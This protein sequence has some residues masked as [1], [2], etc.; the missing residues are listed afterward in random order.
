MSTAT[1]AGGCIPATG[2]NSRLQK[3]VNPAD[4]WEQGSILQLALDGRLGQDIGHKAGVRQRQHGDGGGGVGLQPLLNGG[5]LIGVPIS[6]NH[7]VYHCYLHTIYVSHKCHSLL[8]TSGRMLR[9]LPDVAADQFCWPNYEY[10][11]F[12]YRSKPMPTSICKVASHWRSTHHPFLQVWQQSCSNWK[13]TFSEPPEGQTRLHDVYGD[14]SAAACSYAV[15]S[16]YQASHTRMQHTCCAMTCS[17]KEEAEDLLNLAAT[18][19]EHGARLGAR[20]TPQPDNCSWQRQ[21]QAR[22]ARSRC[23][24]EY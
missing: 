8:S 23:L 14:C 11:L 24:H 21:P 17:S 6:R 3:P 4:L 10:I 18:R 2:D 20:L 9:M 5:P 7:R 13:A 22:T 19:Q 15:S 1:H 16:A 12:C